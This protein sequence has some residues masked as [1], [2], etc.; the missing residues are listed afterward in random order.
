MP[1]IKKIKEIKSK[2]KVKEVKVSTPE[3]TGKENLESEIT[4]SEV[5]E[6]AEFVTGIPKA[7]EGAAPSLVLEAA[8]PREQTR[9]AAERATG[10]TSTTTAPT[11]PTETTES[12]VLYEET[13]RR[14][15]LTTAGTTALYE[16]RPAATVQP[17]RR[18]VRG[19]SPTIE[20][21]PA[22]QATPAEQRM[23]FE[24]P[25]LSRLTPAPSGREYYE[26]HVEA[27]ETKVK[28]KLP[29]E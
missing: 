12:M 19:V 1:K 28:R 27:K 3:E 13:Q 17:R 6:F 7:S 11:T 26:E 22:L 2:I 20:P 15:T 10:P 8:P 16:E 18:A 4:E 23:T 29:F 9:E 5:E 25:D 21:E 24:N 14:E